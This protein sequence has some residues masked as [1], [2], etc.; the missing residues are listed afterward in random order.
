MT[1]LTQVFFLAAIGAMFFSLDNVYYKP[2]FQ[3]NTVVYV[4]VK[5]P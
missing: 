1:K 4:V 5:K 3:S 2:V